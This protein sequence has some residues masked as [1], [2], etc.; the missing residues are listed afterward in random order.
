MW[1]YKLKHNPDALIAHFKAH[2]VA[3][4]YHQEHGLDYIETFSPVVKQGT[5]RLVLAVAVHF[6]RSFP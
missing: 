2:L 3:K 4:G 1:V 6:N 5:I